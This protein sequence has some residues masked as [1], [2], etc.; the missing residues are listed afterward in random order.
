MLTSPA[1]ASVSPTM[2]ANPAPLRFARRSLARNPPS[3]ASSTALIPASRSSSAT[4][5]ATRAAAGPTAATHAAGGGRLRALPRFRE[6]GH[7]ALDAGGETH[8]GCRSAADLFDEPVVSPPAAD[9]VLRA[10]AVGGPLEDG[11][12]VIVEAPHQARVYGGGRPG[13]LEHRAQRV[14]VVARFRVEGVQQLRSRLDDALHIG[15]LAVED[16]QR[17]RLRPAPGVLVEIRPP[18]E[19]VFRETR[20]VGAAR[21]RRAEGVELQPQPVEAET[22]PQAGGDEDDLRVRLRPGGPKISPPSWWNWRNRPFWGRSWRNIGPMYQRRWTPRWMK[23]FSMPARTQLAVCSGRS[24]R[25][26]PSRSGNEYISFSTM[27]VAPPI[28]RTN[29]SVRSRRGVRISSNP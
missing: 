20:A 19:E 3:P 14:E 2:T 13:F 21:V 24:V 8:S 28:E 12:R 5:G 4:A 1:A 7:E 26:S 9:R 29:S 6:Q 27:S 10:E 22:P 25:L 23:P 11:L 15:I 17:I 18:V 16:A